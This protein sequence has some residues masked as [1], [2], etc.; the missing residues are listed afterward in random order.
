MVNNF[1]R[2]E[3][4]LNTKGQ[5]MKESSTFADNVVNNFHS[6]VLFLD[7]KGQY[8]RESNTLANF[9]SIRQLQREV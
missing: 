5:H 4:W 2:R 8:M 3:I 7:T 1:L 9:A 6:R